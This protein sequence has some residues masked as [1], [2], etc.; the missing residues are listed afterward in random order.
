VIGTSNGQPYAFKSATLL[1]GLTLAGAL[2]LL[3]A[4]IGAMQLRQGLA[5]KSETPIAS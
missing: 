3:T 2:A 4:I 1:P 5:A